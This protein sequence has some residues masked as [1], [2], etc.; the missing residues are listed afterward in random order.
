MNLT[1]VETCSDILTE[2]QLQTLLLIKNNRCDAGII[3]KDTGSGATLTLFACHNPDGN[4]LRYIREL[5]VNSAVVVILCAVSSSD[6][7]ANNSEFEWRHVLPPNCS[8][9]FS[10]N[11]GLDI[12]Q[13][14]RFLASINAHGKEIILQH[15]GI[16]QICLVNDSCLLIRDLSPI[17]RWANG[18][19]CTRTYRNQD[20]CVWGVTK[21][22]EGPEH[23]Q[24]Y[25]M[26]FSGALAVHM[27]L[28]YV[29]ENDLF[30]QLRS[31]MPGHDKDLRARQHVIQRFE[32]GLSSY[33]TS[34]GLHLRAM[35]TA[36]SLTGDPKHKHV[37]PSYVLWK[38][39]ALDAQCPVVKRKHLPF[40]IG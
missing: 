21:S 4:A 29:H 35:H 10:P 24:S 7:V 32:I 14:W 28:R 11:E 38:Q 5:A 2:Q 30:A 23:L 15:L 36:E 33:L 39:M 18:C 40:A 13:H 3:D 25:F 31:L 6:G 1:C 26:G 12:G 17:F 16:T 20:A 27:L 22:F 9:C 19:M 37:N 8:V 34:N